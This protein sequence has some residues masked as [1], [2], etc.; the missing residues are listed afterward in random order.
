MSSTVGVLGAGA[1][2][3]ITAHTL[4]K[5]GFD[6]KILT[7]DPTPGGVWAKHRILDGVTINK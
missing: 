7:R 6:V 5:D 2:G 4:L 3:L 1:A